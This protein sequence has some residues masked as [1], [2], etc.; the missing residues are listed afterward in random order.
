MIRIFNVIMKNLIFTVVILGVISLVPLTYAESVPDWVKNTAGWWST[1]AISETEFVNAIEFL[2]KDSIIQVTSTSSTT[3]SESVPDWVKNTAGWWST[4]A[5]SETE[6]VNAIEFLVNIGIISIQGEN[7]CV[8]D[9][10]KYF[11]DKQKI[12]D[13]CEKHESEINEELIPF[14]T[15][16][17]FNSKGF[18]GDEF[19]EEKSLNVYRIFM[20]GGSTMLSA[21]TSNNATIPAILQRIFDSQNLDLEI[22]VINAGISGGNSSTELEL[23]KSKI[24]N[25][26][27]DLV[28]MYDGWNDLSTDLP[29]K[30]IIDNYQLACESAIQNNYELIITLQPIAGFGGKSLTVQEKIN[31]LT[32]QDHNGY[33][34]L[35]AKSSYDYLGRELR[36]LDDVVEE[37]FGDVCTANNLRSVFDDVSGPIYWDQGHVLYAG[38]MILAEK[39]FELSM[40]KIDPNFIPEQKF[41]KIISQYNS[42][43]SLSYLF[44]KLGIDDKMFSSNFRNISEM[45]SEKGKYFQL[46]DEFGNISK[47]FVGKDLRNVDLNS[48]N[49]TGHDLTG[50]NLSGM[51]LR[52]VDFTNTI[53]RDAN[54]SYTNLEGKSFSGIDIRGIDFSN[55]NLKNANFAGASISKAIQV[56]SGNNDE[57]CTDFRDNLACTKNVVQNESIRINFSNADLTNAEF[58]SLEGDPKKQIIYFADFT[59]A[60]LTG[61]NL[62]NVKFVG[63]DFS[64][65]DLNNIVG[66]RLIFGVSDFSNVEM[67]NF[68]FSDIWFLEVLFDNA[69]MKNGEFNYLSGVNVSFKNTDLDGTLF[70][71]SEFSG[72]V[73]MNCKNNL[74]CN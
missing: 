48:Y 10:L 63:A 46:K 6:F 45:E 37:N 27:P 9:F 25:Y 16:L 35:Q 55:A 41:S 29:I 42:K 26:D 59:N 36:I 5:I 20:V 60:T 28:I 13:V 73:N 23:I 74:N 57:I 19:S 21:E 66:E 58:G 1:D 24:V 72:S 33:Q 62:F 49:L 34:L 70:K 43:S 4:D 31:S 71:E 39:F 68:E 12:L 47:S 15:E 51:D 50:A 30:H 40:N 44:D 17:N 69:E 67:N 3:S 56:F 14:Y 8:N 54:L 32:G 18:R 2:I 11:N 64:N 61:V 22:E 65:A 52:N 53:I 38:N 7:K